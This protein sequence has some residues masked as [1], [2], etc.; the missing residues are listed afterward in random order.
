MIF[1][2]ITLLWFSY[3]PVRFL[4]IKWKNI[5]NYDNLGL[6]I[7]SIALVA[8]AWKIVADECMFLCM[9]KD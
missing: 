5:P 2:A 7:A 1:S 6:L 4:A 8:L 9:L 3:Y